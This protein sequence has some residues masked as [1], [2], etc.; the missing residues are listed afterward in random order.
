MYRTGD[1]A[2]YLPTGDLEHLGR[3]DADGG[4]DGRD[5]VHATRDDDGRRDTW[6]RRFLHAPSLRIA[7]GSDQVQ[8]TIIGERALGLPREP[9]PDAGRPWV[10]T[11]RT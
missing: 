7:G 5:G 4:T 3:I 2:R 10:E 8:A 11:R 1:L 6:L 9:D